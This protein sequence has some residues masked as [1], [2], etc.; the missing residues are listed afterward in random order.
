VDLGLTVRDTCTGLEWEKKTQGP[1]LHEVSEYC[2]W[3][4]CC[5]GNCSAPGTLCQPNALAAATCAAH[6]DGS[7]YGCGTCATGE[8]KIRLGITTRVWD[9]VSR[10]NVENFAGHSDWRL[11]S[12]GAHNFPATGDKELETILLYPF[13]CLLG[14]TQSCIAPVFGPT[15]YPNGFYWSATTIFEAPYEYSD[16]VYF[17]GFDFGRVGATAKPDASYV[18]AVR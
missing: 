18:R 17:A 2:A 5:D 15:Q 6:A 7:T 11:P 12:E 16:L 8:C 9:W 10:L 4:G 1:G 13:V 3:A 14:Y